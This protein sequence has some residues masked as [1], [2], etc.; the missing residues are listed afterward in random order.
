M[1]GKHYNFDGP[2]DLMFASPSHPLFIGRYLSSASTIL[3]TSPFASVE[4]PNCKESYKWG[5]MVLLAYW[6]RILF[7]KL[8]FR[9]TSDLTYLPHGWEIQFFCFCPNDAP[10]VFNIRYWLWKHLVGYGEKCFIYLRRN[11]LWEVFWKPVWIVAYPDRQS[12]FY[13][14]WI[15]CEVV[16]R[17][18]PLWKEIM[19]LNSLADVAE[20]PI[21]QYVSAPFFGAMAF[22]WDPI[23][24][25][26]ITYSVFV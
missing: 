9:E 3:S 4:F 13:I 20:L 2:R 14:L 17:L 10:M 24:C 6:L 11:S 5:Y 19:S 16:K 8:G 7:W 22:F 23:P 12:V 26:I 21:R 1:G 15:G 25:A 18:H